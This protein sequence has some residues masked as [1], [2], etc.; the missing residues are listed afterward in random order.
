MSDL[1][2]RVAAI[3]ATKAHYEG[4][5]FQW[6]R[7]DCARV[8]VSH[9]RRLG[10][11]TRNVGKAGSYDSALGAKRA[12]RRA[13]YDNLA[14]ALDGQ[15]LARIPAASALPGDLIVVPGSDS[16]D[17][18]GVWVGTGAALMFHEE[19]EGLVTMI[20]NHPPETAWRV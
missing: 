14:E 9:M 13:G 12:L 3:E 4:R 2:A 15:G 8:A 10:R 6:G 20:L 18:I 16:L 1:L 17:A 5:P 11:R 19:A 7:V